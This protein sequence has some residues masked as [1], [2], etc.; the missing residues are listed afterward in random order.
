MTDPA[1]MLVDDAHAVWSKVFLGELGDLCTQMGDMTTVPGDLGFPVQRQWSNASAKAGHHPCAPV[2]KTPYFTAFPAKLD[3]IAV[4]DDYGRSINTQGLKVGVGKSRT[5]DLTMYSDGP[6][7][8]WS[9][10]VMDLTA[11][12]GS[13]P[14]EFS[15]K[16]NKT[17][18]TA[19]D[20]L[21]L[22]LT[23]ESAATQGQGFLLVSQSGGVTNLWPVWVIN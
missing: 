22:T 8:S 17:K 21:Q 6:M 13:G 12:H 14:P 16:L 19:G 1:Y 7:A 2:E 23:G 10:Q 4:T 20:T 18:G 5:I 9:V 3:P 15:Y 11:V